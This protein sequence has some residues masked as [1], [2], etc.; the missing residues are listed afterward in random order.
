MAL[1]SRLLLVAEDV[2]SS[3]EHHHVRE[4]VAKA[5]DPGVSRTEHPQFTGI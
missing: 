1:V 3:A 4:V 2:M 5:Q